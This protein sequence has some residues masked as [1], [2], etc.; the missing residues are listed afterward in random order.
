MSVTTGADIVYIDVLDKDEG[1]ALLDRQAR[2]FLGMSGEQFARA[3]KEGAF[4]EDA[5]RKPELRRL[6]MLLPFAD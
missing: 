6:A 3:W 2:Q 4:I 1:M 5:D